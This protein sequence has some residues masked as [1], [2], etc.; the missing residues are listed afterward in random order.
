M[1][2]VPTADAICPGGAAT[3]CPTGVPY[4]PKPGGMCG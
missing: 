3:G 4:M 2:G 1:T